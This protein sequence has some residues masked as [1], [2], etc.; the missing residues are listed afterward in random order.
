MANEF[1]FTPFAVGGAQRPDS[2]SGLS[3]EFR[4]A[5]AQMVQGAP[6]NIRSGIRFT[7]GYRSPERQAQLWEG[8]LQKYGSPEAARKWVAPPGNSKHNHGQAVDFKWGNDEAKNWVHQNAKQFGLNFP[9]SNEDWHIEPIGARGHDHAPAAP[10]AMVAG[11][12]PMNM[13]PGSPA[14]ALGP[15]REVATAPAVGVQEQP[16][17]GNPIS[18][19]P[20]KEQSMLGALFANMQPAAEAFGASMG[21]GQ[22]GPS[23]TGGETSGFAAQNA[24]MGAESAKGL[25]AQLNPDIEAMLSL[26]GKKKPGMGII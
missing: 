24:M 20:G 15:A 23:A 13:Q 9:L 12:G 6:E 2:F 19:P 18:T 14:P 1:D 7:S 21:A 5:L 26:G 10:G 3:P 16:V 8:A 22:Q 4:A 17:M 11:S 25:L